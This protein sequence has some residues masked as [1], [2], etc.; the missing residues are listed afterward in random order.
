M[1]KD[2]STCGYLWITKDQALMI[3]DILFDVF[4]RNE[5]ENMDLLCDLAYETIRT[6]ERF[7][8]QEVKEC[9]MSESSKKAESV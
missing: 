8:E 2:Y 4:S 9:A 7:R 1:K 6:L 3:K 5:S